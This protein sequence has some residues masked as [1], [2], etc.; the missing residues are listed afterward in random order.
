MLRG[1]AKHNPG[2]GQPERLQDS[3]QDDPGG[4]HTP[5]QATQGNHSFCEQHVAKCRLLDNIA[6]IA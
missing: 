6:L 5:V 3:G 2:R 1:P 4:P